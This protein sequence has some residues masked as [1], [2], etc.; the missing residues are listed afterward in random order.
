MV[1]REAEFMMKQYLIN[2]YSLINSNDYILTARI[3]SGT[4]RCFYNMTM[5]TI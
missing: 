3:G 5:E 1:G 4:E 2:L